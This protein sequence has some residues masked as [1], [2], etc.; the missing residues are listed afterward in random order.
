MT[1]GIF[2]PK[3]LLRCAAVCLIL[4][5]FYLVT[6]EPRVSGNYLES[7]M[8]MA[9]Y[10]K[11]R[12]WRRGL[13]HTF[14]LIT[15]AG[16]WGPLAFVMPY[17]IIF[18]LGTTILGKAFFV[19]RE[20][21]PYYKTHRDWSY[22]PILEEDCFNDYQARLFGNSDGYF[23]IGVTLPLVLVCLHVFFS[24]S[25]AKQLFTSRSRRSDVLVAKASG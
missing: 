1:L 2:E 11:A 14:D 19:L 21:R 22:Q 9:T 5:Y 24:S 12:R 7:Y 17:M 3:T 16:Q 25:V 18:P 13:I 15:T 8:Y 23:Q 4:L 6:T 20:L 10:T